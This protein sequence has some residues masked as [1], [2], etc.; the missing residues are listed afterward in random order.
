MDGRRR[1]GGGVSERPKGG[2]GGKWRLRR[3]GRLNR[4]LKDK[5]QVIDRASGVAA[6]SHGLIGSWVAA[7]GS[8]RLAVPRAT[9]I[10]RWPC[11]RW[12][13]R[14]GLWQPGQPPRTFLGVFPT[15]T[16]ASEMAVADSGPEQSTSSNPTERRFTTTRCQK[17]PSRGAADLPSPLGTDTQT[18]RFLL[19][20]FWGGSPRCGNRSNRVPSRNSG[21]TTRY[22]VRQ[23]PKI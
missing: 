21:P 12:R 5:R 20:H 2:A 19:A 9:R 16:T 8:C 14:S 10:I 15:R 7:H 18:C 22:R 23:R 3:Y 13:L 6:S 11:E 4:N 17:T 1:S